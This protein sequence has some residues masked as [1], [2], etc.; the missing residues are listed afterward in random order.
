MT[1]LS[2]CPNSIKGNYEGY[3]PI[4]IVSQKDD[5]LCRHVANSRFAAEKE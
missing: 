3:V 5:V 1:F 4:Y 2:Y